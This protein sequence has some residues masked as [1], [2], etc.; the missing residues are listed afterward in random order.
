MKVTLIFPH[1]F[2]ET[3]GDFTYLP[4][5]FSKRTPEG[6]Y[7]TLLTIPLALPT[8]A[9]LTPRDVEVKIVDEAIDGIDYEE[10][11]DVVGISFYSTLAERAYELADGFRERGV[12]VC[13][14]GA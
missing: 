12:H 9:A 1:V 5:L 14:G 8:L 3:L 10:E 2:H 4:R 7:S 11:T 13:L 6:R